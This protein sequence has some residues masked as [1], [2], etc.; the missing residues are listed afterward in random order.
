L[1][2]RAGLTQSDIARRLDMSP[3]GYQ[4][5]E[6]GTSEPSMDSLQVISKLLNVSVEHLITGEKA[7]FLIA[8]PSLRYEECGS[9]L[10]IVP[11][12]DI[13]A[14]AGAG[15]F[16]DDQPP[17]SCLA[18]RNEFIKADLKTT[19]AALFMVSAVGDSMEP[20][21]RSG[22]MLLCDRSRKDYRADGIY[23][24]RMSDQL[25]VK[26]IQALTGG[27]LRLTSSNPLY[28]PVDVQ[29]GDSDFEVLARVIWVCKRIV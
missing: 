9:D 10:S 18:L 27:M 15:A 24:V 8:E 7:P 28:Q 25:V 29:A 5:Y 2:K 19:A 21:I 16:N 22:D 3:A 26:F 4:R 11:V 14:A 20:T 17:V 12:Y 23:I 6:N 13:Q 1:R